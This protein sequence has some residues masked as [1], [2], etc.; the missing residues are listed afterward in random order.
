MLQTGKSVF[1]R[2]LMEQNRRKNLTN[3]KKMNLK[4]DKCNYLLHDVFFCN[5]FI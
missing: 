5:F 1:F 3:Q 4:E 2:R